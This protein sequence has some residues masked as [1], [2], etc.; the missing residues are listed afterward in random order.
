MSMK[1]YQEC[2]DQTFYVWSKQ[3]VIFEI[4]AAFKLYPVYTVI[5]ATVVYFSVFQSVYLN[6]LIGKHSS[7]ISKQCSYCIII[8]VHSC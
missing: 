7:G 8:T 2:V 3:N 4:R 1:Q 6:M 5:M